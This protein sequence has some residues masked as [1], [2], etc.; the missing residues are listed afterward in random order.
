MKIQNLFIFCTLTL[1]Q[2]MAAQ[3]Y[4]LHNSINFSNINDGR[5]VPDGI[6]WFKP[7]PLLYG[8]YRTSGVFEAPYYQQLKLAFETGIIIDGGYA[9]GKSGTFIQPNDGKVGIGTSTPSGKL[10][11][12]GNSAVYS[13]FVSYSGTTVNGILPNGKEPTLVISEKI[14]GAFTPAVGGQVTYRGGVS[15][16]RGGLV[17]IL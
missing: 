13:D 10:E 11:V 5:N 9:Y 14:S 8:I 16:G 12:T 7:A 6:T 3:T 17:F 4:E 2:L 1:F 15:F